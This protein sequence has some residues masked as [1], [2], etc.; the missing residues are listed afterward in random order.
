MTILNVAC[1]KGKATVEID[2]DKLPEEVYKEALL[3]GLKVLLNRGMSKITKEQHTDPEA[4]KAEA[5]L[6]AAKNVDDLYAGK[7]KITGGKAKSGVSGAV[8]TEARRLAKNA[9]KDAIKRAG[10]KVSHVEA[11]EITRAA[12]QLLTEDPSFI[13]KAKVNIADREA[14][15]ISD[16]L[17]SSIAISPKLVEKAEARKAKDQLSAKQAGKVAVRKKGQPQANA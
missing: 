3:Q 2:T 16:S 11:K 15:P 14:A 6:K 5:M 10:K 8:M 4:L 17:I 12:N 9:V 7:V 1:T 13:E